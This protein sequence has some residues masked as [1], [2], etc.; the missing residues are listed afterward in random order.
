M[1]HVWRSSQTV[2]SS[3]LCELF[4]QICFLKM[5]C[6]ADHEFLSDHPLEMM[7]KEQITLGSGSFCSVLNSF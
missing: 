1:G 7:S 2:V 6:H 5:L 3:E 4:Y